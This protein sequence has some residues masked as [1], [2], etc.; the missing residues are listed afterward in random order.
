[1]IAFATHTPFDVRPV[2]EAPYDDGFFT[3]HWIFHHASITK[4]LGYYLFGCKDII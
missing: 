3:R 4:G 1:M 2:T